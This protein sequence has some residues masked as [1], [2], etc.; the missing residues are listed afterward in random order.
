MEEA[1]YQCEGRGLG[2]GVKNSPV[3]FGLLS[4]QQESNT[5]FSLDE[6]VANSIIAEY[7]NIKLSFISLQGKHEPF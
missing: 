1:E 6:W 2:K 4:L 3:K 7:N 5:L